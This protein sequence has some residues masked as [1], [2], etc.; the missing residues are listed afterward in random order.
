MTV[1]WGANGGQT[2][3]AKLLS[4]SKRGTLTVL[5]LAGTVD[6]SNIGP[7]L[8]G[9]D[10]KSVVCATK[11]FKDVSVPF[12]NQLPRWIENND[13]S[14]TTWQVVEG[15]DAKKINDLP[16]GYVQHGKNQLKPH[17]HTYLS[18]RTHFQKS[19]KNCLIISAYSST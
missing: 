15:L 6:E 1:F 16:D 19:V 17:I 7:K 12:W 4:N 11:M 5:V 2:L 9:Y 13:L 14:P 10:K 18:L 3:G 8:A